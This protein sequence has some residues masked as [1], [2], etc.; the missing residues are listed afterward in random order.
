VPVD[1]RGDDAKAWLA[2]VFDRAAATYDRVGEPYHDFFGER[3]VDLAGVSAGHSVLD[4][5]CGRGAALLP[6]TRRVG[7]RG[8]T[9]GVDF[10][11]T[12]VAIAAAALAD[13]GLR[14]DARV[15]DAEHLD[16]DDASFD[17][18]LCAFGL[19]FFPD[20]EAAIA[21]MFR[22]IRA[23]GVVAVSTWGQ[24]DE[25]WSW[26][27]DVFATLTASRRAVV[28]PFAE[29]GEVVSLLR[30][31]GFDDVTAQLE[32]HD[33]RFADEDTWWGW[34]WSFSLRGV[35][36][37]QDEATL[38]RLRREAT[39]RLR[40]QQQ[41]SGLVRRLTANFVRGRRPVR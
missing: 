6:A 1:A 18:A 32:H 20:P 3:L 17:A 41:T 16:V 40:V 33:V 36:E 38:D 34:L 28:R 31:A 5:A 12:M 7:D 15:M 10:S 11:P 21:E 39:A 30:G 9:L 26:E 14:G 25:R 22:V 24:D 37:Q 8:R 29:P 13:E 2:G 35:L 4:V 19:F 27:D 23:G